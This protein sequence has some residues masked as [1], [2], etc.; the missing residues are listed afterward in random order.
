MK[1]ILFGLDGATYTI[2][3]PLME[4]GIMPNLK[5][6]RDEG[7]ACELESTAMPITPQA[8]TTLATGVTAGVHGFNDFVRCES[9]K[10]GVFFRVNDSRDIHSP[11]IW[12]IA[13]Q[14]GRQVT[15][16]NYIGTAPPKP[17]HGHSIP[18][19]TSGRH[20]RRSSFPSDLFQHLA[21]I[22][23][24]DA[25]K[26]G[27]DYDI[28]QLALQTMEPGRWREWIEH[29]IEREQV[30]FAVMKHLM[31]TDPSDLTAIVLDGVDKI[32]HL[33]YRLIDPKYRPGSPS[34]WEAEMIDL[35]R[36]YYAQ[37]DRFLG[38]L[39][40]LVGPWARIVIAS[41]HGFTAT[42][43]VVYINKWLSDQGWLT[44]RGE[45][46][47]DNK[48]AV[49]SDRMVDLAN[50]IDLPRTKAYALTP[51]CNGIFIN[52]EADQY[53]SFREEL[54]TKLTTLRGPDGGQI[55]SDAKK[56]EDVFAG[57]YMHRAPDL[58]L[59]LRDH[60]LISV[61][62]A[63]TAVIPRSEV[64]GTHHPHGIL[65]ARG[66]GILAGKH[67]QLRNILD[68][69]PLLMHSLGL[70]IPAHFQGRHPS[71]FY[72]PS[73]LASDPVRWEASSATASDDA[74][75]LHTNT[76]T[77]AFPDDVELDENEEAIVWER[78]KSLGYVE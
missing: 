61:L 17:I 5:R 45:V 70:N 69:T 75:V 46:E 57:P 7:A 72:D 18:G 54:I 78:L 14:A 21:E 59:T 60:G 73:Y 67:L 77:E 71:A 33:A 35:C 44:W 50:G 39:M 4:D 58:T 74:D 26:L 3:E 28:E 37:V 47:E 36:S 22:P 34:P 13:S 51:S 49:F 23:G 25:A 16:L 52:V 30:W 15:V 56:R 40:Q 64:A 42:T 55:I 66:P 2:L 62:N 38:E 11:T 32:Q 24:L 63:S 31:T 65:I 48:Q 20:M 29:H 76:T 8:W 12:E 41:D 43:E 9:S 6:F 19:F 68:V 27:L 10:D 1:T 53:E